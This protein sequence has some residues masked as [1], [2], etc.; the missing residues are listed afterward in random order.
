MTNHAATIMDADAE[1]RWREWQARGAAD[2]RRTT[3]RMRTLMLVIGTALAL[4]FA[5]QLA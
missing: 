1:R 4:W 2:D 5:V 3:A